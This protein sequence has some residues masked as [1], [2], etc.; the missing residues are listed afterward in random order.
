M[1]LHKAQ[2]KVFEYSGELLTGL[3]LLSLSAVANA[4]FIS[5]NSLDWDRGNNVRQTHNI[6]LSQITSGSLSFRSDATAIQPDSLFN[7]ASNIE[8][9]LEVNY[10]IFIPENGPLTL[11]TGLLTTS[12]V[13]SMVIVPFLVPLSNL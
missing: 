13:W 7:N 11:T 3:I 8:P 2:R 12:T 10:Y 9:L 6:V 4:T 1:F 5:S